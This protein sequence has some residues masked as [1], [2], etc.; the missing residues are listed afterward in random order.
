MYNVE[1]AAERKRRRNRST[2][3]GTINTKT[4][5]VPVN[6]CNPWSEFE[7]WGGKSWFTGHAKEE[8]EETETHER[9][10]RYADVEP[11][12]KS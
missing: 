4:G 10:E 9:A 6:T 2:M 8:S 11:R 12:S 5:E 7:A 1:Q 3:K